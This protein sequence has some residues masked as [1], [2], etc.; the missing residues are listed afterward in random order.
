MQ[1]KHEIKDVWGESMIHAVQDIFWMAN[2]KMLLDDTRFLT[3]EHSDMVVT[4]MFLKMDMFFFRRLGR[5]Q[6]RRGNLTRD[7]ITPVLQRNMIIF[8]NNGLKDMEKHKELFGSL[9]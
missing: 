8:L 5:N 4:S 9:K 7:P 3:H 6:T 2:E 1:L